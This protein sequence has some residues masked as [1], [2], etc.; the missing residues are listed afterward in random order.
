VYLAVLLLQQFTVDG[1]TTATRHAHC[2]SQQYLSNHLR[3]FDV[4][5]FAVD[6]Q[7]AVVSRSNSA[8]DVMWCF[9]FPYY[10][11]HAPP[12]LLLVFSTCFQRHVSRIGFCF[13]CAFSLPGPR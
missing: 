4:S 1:W 11:P 5:A 7:K 9:C 13:G 8:I 2:S 12:A 10:R 6:Q 3:C